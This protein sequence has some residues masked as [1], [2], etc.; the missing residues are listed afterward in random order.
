VVFARFSYRAGLGWQLAFGG[1][2]LALPFLVLVAIV[3]ALTG[4][5]WRYAVVAALCAAALP[6]GVRLGVRIRDY[7]FRHRLRPRYEAI[8][9][10]IERGP[11]PAARERTEIALA[12]DEKDLAMRVFA[13]RDGENGLRVEFLWAVAFPPRHT[14]FVYSSTGEPTKRPSADWRYD[15]LDASWFVA[16]G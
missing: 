6:A 15:R 1:G 4:H 2:L 10:R 14:L 13:T 11:R 12:D 3:R 7:D 16:R 9:R 5:G 8:I